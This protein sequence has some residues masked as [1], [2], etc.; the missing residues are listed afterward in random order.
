[1]LERPSPL[2]QDGDCR[3]GPRR[4]VAE[5]EGDVAASDERDPSGQLLQ[6]KKLVAAGEM[7]LP[8]DAQPGRPRAHCYDQVIAVEHVPADLDRTLVKETCPPVE[9]L[10]PCVDETVLA[11]LGERVRECGLETDQ[12]RPVDA[13]VPG[14][15]SALHAAPPI[16]DLGRSHQHLLGVTAPQPARAAEGPGVD[17]RHRPS[18]RPALQGR[19][20][21][22]FSRSDHDDLKGLLHHPSSSDLHPFDQV[23]L[24]LTAPMLRRYCPHAVRTP[25]QARLRSHRP[26]NEPRG[27][28]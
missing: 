16:D 20:R 10:H 24:S 1:M 21:A 22:G 7:V 12:L 23:A 6:V 18:G 8:L 11:L 15:A 5:L 19:R 9:G 3:P 25:T 4:Y 13:Q 17:H 14:D 26:M 2:V 28:W 27:P